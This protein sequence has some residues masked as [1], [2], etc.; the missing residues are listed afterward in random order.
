[1]VFA[2]PIESILLTVPRIET[3]VVIGIPDD[4]NGQEQIAALVSLRDT[5]KKPIMNGSA[6]PG[7]RILQSL[8]HYLLKEK[9]LPLFWLPTVLRVLKS[10]ES[11]PVNTRGKVDKKKVRDQ[12]FNM[13]LKVMKEH[14]AFETI[15]IGD[16]AEHNESDIPWQYWAWDR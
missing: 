2:P 3:A 8:H 12:F 13:N 16:I 14:D 5:D 6:H 15:Q 9:E 11:V 10:E 1:M 4:I 7:A